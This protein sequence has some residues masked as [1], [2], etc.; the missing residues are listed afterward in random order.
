MSSLLT[1]SLLVFL[2]GCYHQSGIEHLSEV[3]NTCPDYSLSTY[4]Y[5]TYDISSNPAYLQEATVQDG[6]PLNSAI[7]FISNDEA[8]MN[9]TTID[10]QDV[11]NLFSETPTDPSI[12]ILIDQD[13]SLDVVL[14]TLESIYLSGRTD[15]WVVSALEPQ[16]QPASPD[17]DHFSGIQSELS[18]LRPDLR[19]VMVARNLTSKLR[20]CPSGKKVFEDVSVLP[21][22]QKCEALVDGFIESLPSCFLTNTNHVS[23]YTQV[24]FTPQ[25]TPNLVQLQLKPGALGIDTQGKDTWNDLLPLLI[26]TNEAFWVGSQGTVDGQCIGKECDTPE[27]KECNFIPKECTELGTTYAEEAYKKKTKEEYIA[28]FE[29]AENLWTFSCSRDESKG[30]QRLTDLYLN[31][32]LGTESISKAKEYSGKAIA[33][34]QK[35]C[36][37]GNPEDCSS[38]GREYIW[39]FVLKQD[40]VKGV[41]LLTKGCDG[42]DPTGCLTL[43]ELYAE[44]APSKAVAFFERSCDL[45]FGEGCLKAAYEHE[46]PSVGQAN[47]A[48]VIKWYQKGCDAENG[49]ACNNLATRYFVGRGV[50]KDEF[51]GLELFEKS[52]TLQ[53]RLGCSNLAS[54]YEEG[55]AGVFE[56]DI[57]KAIDFYQRACELEDFSSCHKVKQLTQEQ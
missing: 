21:G 56:K 32:S 16:I 37:Q 17:P 8:S 14:P 34:Y 6:V 40:R 22:E 49:T 47:Q 15:I 51:K 45:N 31:G 44:D 25:F 42:A 2:C 12:R 20:M 28:N 3:R 29:I 30:C 27:L 50:A 54:N 9:D 4:T 23:N 36:E 55:K 57:S 5:T 53:E 18:T 48:E 24:L 13:T 7:L 41:E 35:G 11:M 38:L 33:L 19:S 39:P 10:T 46:Y 43:G 52:C 26:E 1:R